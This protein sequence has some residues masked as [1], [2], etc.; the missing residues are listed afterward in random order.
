MFAFIQLQCRVELLLHTQYG[1]QSLKCLLSSFFKEKVSNPLP[2]GSDPCPFLP[3]FSLL[4]CSSH[5]DSLLFYVCSCHTAILYAVSFGS[6]ISS[7]FLSHITL[8]YVT[9]PWEIF[10]DNLTENSMVI[11]LKIHTIIFKDIIPSLFEFKLFP[12]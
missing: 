6:E 10:L 5:A 9:F 3:L 11:K 2:T 1:L 8:E 4:F 12:F 7:D